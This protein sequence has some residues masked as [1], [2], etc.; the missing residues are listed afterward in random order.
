MPTSLF[1]R[2]AG[3]VGGTGGVKLD[4]ELLVTEAG[5]ELLTRYPYDLVLLPSD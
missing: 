3:L 2:Y 1:R 4:D 5:S